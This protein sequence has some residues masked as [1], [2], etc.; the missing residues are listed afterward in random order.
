M[1]GSG[2][3]VCVMA[4]SAEVEVTT[5]TVDVDELLLLFGSVKSFAM[6]AVF[7]ITVPGAVPPLTVT[8]KVKAADVKLELLVQVIVPVAPTDG[9]IQVQPA[10]G[11]PINLNVVLAGMA[12]VTVVLVGPSVL[13]L[14]VAVIV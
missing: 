14:L 12:S 5:V 4:T 6:V 1:T 10:G 11:A 3:S 7:V 13:L 8:V 2:E 9:V